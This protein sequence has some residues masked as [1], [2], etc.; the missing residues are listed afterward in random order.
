MSFREQ[1]THNEDPLVSAPELTGRT[2]TPRR[3]LELVTSCLFDAPRGTG[4][5]SPTTAP[6]D[7]LSLESNTHVGDQ[8]GRQRRPGS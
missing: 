5:T 3:L 7:V 8:A 6:I 1:A 2:V 4:M